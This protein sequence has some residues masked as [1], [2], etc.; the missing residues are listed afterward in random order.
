MFPFF[1]TSSW[2][3]FVLFPVSVLSEFAGESIG[4]RE[5]RVGNFFSGFLCLSGC[6]SH[7]QICESG[8]LFLKHW[9][10]WPFLRAR[11]ILVFSGAPT[12]S[13]RR[14]ES[15]WRH[16]IHWTESL[17]R[18]GLGTQNWVALPLVLLGLHCNRGTH[19]YIR[20]TALPPLAE[21]RMMMITL[22]KKSVQRSLEAWPYRRE[23]RGHNPTKKSVTT[24]VACSVGKLHVHTVDDSVQY[25]EHERKTRRD[26]INTGCCCYKF[27][28]FNQ[29]AESSDSCST[30]R[31]PRNP[32]R[33]RG[34]KTSRGP[35]EGKRQIVIAHQFGLY[36]F[37]RRMLKEVLNVFSLDR[38][39]K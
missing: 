15:S 36:F 24:E 30:P 3:H 17:H 26:E 8:G 35:T 6:H 29:V 4:A 27:T 37:L 12:A 22:K 19:L 11:S 39:W 5:L 10:L 13:R 16:R 25:I 23:R 1:E 34:A 31:K 28:E 18:S 38:S 14:I 9:R 2:E 21:C 20:T 7:G 32:D 33:H